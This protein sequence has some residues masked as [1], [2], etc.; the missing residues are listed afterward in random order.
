MR[1]TI[2]MDAQEKAALQEEKRLTD[3]ASSEVLL[4]M[5][6]RAFGVIPSEECRDRIT[7]VLKRDCSW[8]S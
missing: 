7:A 4:T 1:I 2:E 5:L 6:E 8:Q 3:E